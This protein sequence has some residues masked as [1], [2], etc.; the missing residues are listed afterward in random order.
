MKLTAAKLAYV[1]SQGLR[2]PSWFIH[3]WT[4]RMD[5][6][7][8]PRRSLHKNEGYNPQALSS[9]RLPLQADGLAA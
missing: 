3:R 2:L 5:L 6:Q 7:A 9:L 1:R 8:F 4:L